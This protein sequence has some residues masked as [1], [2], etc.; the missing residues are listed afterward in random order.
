MSGAMMV[1]A[2]ACGAS[3][4]TLVVKSSGPS[5]RNYQPGKA[6]PDSMK[7]VLKAND[8]VVI[9]DGKGTRTLKGPG[10]F[11]PTMA[12]NHTTDS[13]ASFNAL[14]MQRSE[15]RAR[16][17]AVRSVSAAPEP[18]SPTIWYVDIERSS[19]MCVPDATNVTMWRAEPAPAA[20]VTITRLADGKSETVNWL[21]NQSVKP[22][23]ASM[24]I[25]AGA[26]YRLSWAG[27]AQP[28]TLKF[29][30]LGQTLTG[31]EDMAAALIKNGCEAQLD[32][33]IETVAI[34]EPTA[35]PAG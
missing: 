5:A 19:N 14:A 17:G 22:W 35:K 30:L 7:I 33:L 34:P 31:L 15:R 10:T 25:T 29:A 8:Q 3:A 26:E 16:T 21:K 12:S 4:E 32:L 13:R 1:L 20:A 18:R 24:P 27:A 23:P 28:T 11:S 6:I 2:F 9:L